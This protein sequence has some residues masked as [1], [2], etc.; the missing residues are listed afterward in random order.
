MSCDLESRKTEKENNL[1][2]RLIV[3]EFESSLGVEKALKIL[4]TGPKMGM[5]ERKADQCRDRIRSE[6]S[7]S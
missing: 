7:S 2:L 4:F 5:I 1:D 3:G 6:G